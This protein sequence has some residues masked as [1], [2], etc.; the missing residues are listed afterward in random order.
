ME[1][2]FIP[3]E[4]NVLIEPINP[5]TSTKSWI[6]LPENKESPSKWKVVAI[7]PGKLLENGQRSLM[8]VKVWDLVYF[9]KYSTE[10]I[11][12]SWN[13]YLIVTKTS[14]LGKEE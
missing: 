14:L 4:D 3:L 11:E 12:I 8:D 2:R 1:T 10:Y 6:L 9:K 13:T 7:G 5:E